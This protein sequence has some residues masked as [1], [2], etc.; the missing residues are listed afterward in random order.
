M[1]DFQPSRLRTKNFNLQEQ[2]QEL[3]TSKNKNSNVHPPSFLNEQKNLDN[4]LTLF[5][6][7]KNKKNLNYM[8]HDMIIASPKN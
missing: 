7:L 6:N 8:A 5:L 3:S 1:K 2:K 4:P